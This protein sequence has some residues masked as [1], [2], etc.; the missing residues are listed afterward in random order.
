[1]NFSDALNE[2]KNGT[3][4]CRSSWNKSGMAVFLVEDSTIMVEGY[5][6]VIKKHFVI[7]SPKGSYH[8]YIP[9]VSDLLAEDW[10]DAFYEDDCN[11][12]EFAMIVGMESE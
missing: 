9:N 10:C 2:M 4:M 8:M 6:N 5:A 7:R 11:A 12:A 3:G 1:M